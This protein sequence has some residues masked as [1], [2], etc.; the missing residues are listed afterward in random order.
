MRTLSAIAKEVEACWPNI[1]FGAVPYLRAMREMR[2]ID[3]SYGRDSGR[4]VVMYF[5]ANAEYWRGP[6]ARDVKAEL[7]AML[8]A[9]GR[10]Q[11]DAQAPQ[12]PPGGS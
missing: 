5:L 12:L 4:S 7:K 1:Y 3:D 6:V 8:N 2:T 9:A 11:H 10:K